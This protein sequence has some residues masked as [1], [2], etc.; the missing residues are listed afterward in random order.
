M[1]FTLSSSI[2][3]AIL[4]AILAWP[5]AGCGPTPSAPQAAAIPLESFSGRVL[6]TGLEA[7]WEL[8]FGPDDMLW[9]TEREGRRITRI[10][11]ATGEMTEAITIDE[12]LVD[13]QHQGLLGMAFDP[14][15]LQG[16][17]RN[18]VYVAYTYDATPDD[19]D[20]QDDPRAKVVRLTYSESAE[21]LGEPVELISGVPAGSDH[22]GG[23]LKIGPD[24]LLYYSLGEQGANQFNRYCAPIEAQRLPTL[25]EVEAEDWSAY[26]GKIL[27]MELD[28]SIPADNPE[29]GGVQSHI[30]SYG[31]RNPQGLVFGPDGALYAV[32]HGPNTDDEVNLI[33]AGGNYGWPHIAGYRDDQAYVYANWSAAPDCEQLTWTGLTDPAGIPKSVPVQ[34]ESAWEQDFVEPLKTLFTVHNSYDFED[35]TCGASY[36]ICRPS[37][38]PSSVDVYPHDGPIPGWG[39]SLLATTLKNGAVY[40][41][42]LSGDARGIRD[43]DKLFDTVNRYRDL[44]IGP[45][46]RTFYIATDT[47]GLTRDTEGGATDQ[48]ANPGSILVFTFTG[49]RVKSASR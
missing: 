42:K 32:E 46:D 48:L 29:L 33:E 41:F 13:Q 21:T 34:T 22:N 19:G 17:D 40:R 6:T 36:F 38:A 26:K 18:Y 20:E 1:R 30:F 31:H 28:G 2:L 11:P 39:G 4:L 16:D 12:V 49:G 25:A 47:S 3:L 10:D 45:D 37:V 7:P 14:L 35:E 24:E 9:V 8:S 5:V 27:R 23:R 44:A 15:L 43:V